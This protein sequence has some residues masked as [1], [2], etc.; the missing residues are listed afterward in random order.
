MLLVLI[1]P[2]L[3]KY[4]YNKYFMLILIGHISSGLPRKL[5]IM[6]LEL[7]RLPEVIKLFYS[8]KMHEK[9]TYKYYLNYSITFLSNKSQEVS[10]DVIVLR[11]APGQYW[12]YKGTLT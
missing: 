9:L 2:M 8:E 7:S 5:G 12:R 3:Q 6:S 1:L 4:F 10:I 11:K